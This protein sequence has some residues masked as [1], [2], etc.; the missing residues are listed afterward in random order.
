[1]PTPSRLRVVLDTNVVASAI[2]WGGKPRELLRLARAG[3]ISLFTSV[4][5]LAE[6][7]DILER[8]KFAGKILASLQTVEQIVEGYAELAAVVSP[9]P[10]SGVAPDPD[11]DVVIGTALA[12]QA[13]II[14]TGDK[15]FLSVGIHEGV[16]LMTVGDLLTWADSRPS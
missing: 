15:P 1:M 2:L 10:V 6:L 14:V 4:P 13:K 8:P 7:A 11:D 12:A 16:R 9:F 5:M 3:R